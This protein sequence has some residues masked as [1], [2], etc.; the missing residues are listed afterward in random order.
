MTDYRKFNRKKVKTYKLVLHRLRT[1]KDLSD[2]FNHCYPN[3]RLA[4]YQHTHKKRKSSPLT[5]QL[6]E[7]L[8]LEDIQE[9]ISFSVIDI[10]E[11]KAVAKLEEELQNKL[12]FGVQVLRRIK[13][14]WSQLTLN[15]DWSLQR[16][17]REA[18]IDAQI[19]GVV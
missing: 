15:D 7:G 9:E 16:H 6:A 3:L 5:E 14:K 17:N 18:E 12:G 13:H 8:K 1:L 19:F 11:G 4:F 10:D 2:S